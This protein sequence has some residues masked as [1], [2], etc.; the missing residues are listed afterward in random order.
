MRAP[1]RDLPRIQEEDNDTAALRSPRGGAAGRLR[2]WSLPAD[3][4]LRR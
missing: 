2:V 4:H 1:A 3:M